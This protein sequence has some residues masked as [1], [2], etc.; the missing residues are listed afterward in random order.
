MTDRRR[1]RSGGLA[2]YSKGLSPTKR[3]SGGR[4]K[5]V[6]AAEMTENA[7]IS[8]RQASMHPINVAQWLE[9]NKQS[10]LPP[11]C[12]KLMYACVMVVSRLLV[13]PD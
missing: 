8:S 7:A 4:R 13:F 2:E 3:K 12:N 5:V 1:T 6:A 9:E 11:V 10:F